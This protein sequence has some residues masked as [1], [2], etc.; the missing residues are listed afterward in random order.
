MSVDITVNNKGSEQYWI[1]RFSDSKEEASLQFTWRQ[2][3]SLQSIENKVWTEGVVTLGKASEEYC[4]SLEE[5]CEIVPYDTC[6]TLGCE[7]TEDSYNEHTAKVFAQPWNEW[8]HSHNL[9]YAYASVLTAHPTDSEH[10]G[11][12]IY[13]SYKNR[14]RN[15]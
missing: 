6:L 5:F 2:D 11:W 8:M 10:Q 9:E 3:L 12:Y 15:I 13:R 7:R 4:R 14:D 1:D